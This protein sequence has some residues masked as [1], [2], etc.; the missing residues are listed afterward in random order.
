MR[1][2]DRHIY[3]S[4]DPKLNYIQHENTDY[5]VASISGAFQRTKGGNSS[6]FKL[7]PQDGDELVVK[8][9]RYDVSSVKAVAREAKRIERF[10][11]EIDALRRAKNEGFNNVVEY[12]FD[13]EWSI[14]NRRF[15]YYTMEK[16]D[17]DLTTFLEENDVSDQQRFLLCVNILKGIRE[18]HGAG[19]Y[20]RDIKPDNIL[21]VRGEWKIG[22]LGLADFQDPD[23]DIDEVGERIGPRDW[24]SPEAMNKCLTEKL[25]DK[26]RYKY[27]CTIEAKSDVFQLGKLFW[28]IFQG[29]LPEG[30]VLRKDFRS[31]DASL[32][33]IIYNMLRHSKEKRHSLQ[34]IESGFKTRYAHYGI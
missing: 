16:A 32:Y 4:S 17:S 23:F 3:L 9:S 18:L 15:A 27:D 26:L 5:S 12:Y 8:F 24:L 25:G 22:D 33:E 6:V 1:F 14:G 20:H 31:P 2:S 11:R 29:N 10:R 13:G 21:F 7:I 19:I 28:Y 30:Q 34:D